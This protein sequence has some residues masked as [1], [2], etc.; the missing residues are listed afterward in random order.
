MRTKACLGVL[1]L[2]VVATTPRLEVYV[3]YDGLG[4][5]SGRA[6]LRDLMEE[7]A[8]Q[9]IDAWDAFIA[10]ARSRHVG[11]V[12]IYFNDYV[13]YGIGGGDATAEFFFARYLLRHRPR[14]EGQEEELL[15]HRQMPVLPAD[16]WQGEVERYSLETPA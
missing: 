6:I 14:A 4:G 11:D 10:A 16:G 3:S 2:D 7:L 13:S 8:R 9:G 1:R 5:L 12:H 15:L